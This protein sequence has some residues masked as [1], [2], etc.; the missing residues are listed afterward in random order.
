MLMH[1]PATAER[2]CSDIVGLRL[3]RRYDI[4]LLPSGLINH[5]AAAIRRGLL[6]AAADHLAP[7]AVFALERHDPD[8]LRRAAVG[9]LGVAAPVTCSV[10]TVTHD[11]D[12]VHMTLGYA[13]GER[14]WTHR[15]SARVLDDAAIG[16]ALAEAGFMPPRWVDARWAE[17]T[18][19][20]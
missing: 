11:G 17:A 16:A 1:L 14:R 9:V 15:F 10:E 4:V 12:R 2:V 18:R 13:E 19:R 6:Q 3:G 5:P 20:A 8:W 7:G